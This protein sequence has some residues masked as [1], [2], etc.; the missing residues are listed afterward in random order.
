MSRVYI[1]SKHVIEIIFDPETLKFL[2]L[3]A[4]YKL[5]GGSESL[6]HKESWHSTFSSF[7]PHS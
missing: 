4:F 6:L 5:T 7:P 2:G 3:E 1:R